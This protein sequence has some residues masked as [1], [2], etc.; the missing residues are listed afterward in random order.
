MR[1]FITLL[2]CLIAPPALAGPEIFFMAGKD[3]RDTY[4]F[5]S[6]PCT[7]A[8]TCGTGTSWSDLTN[9]VTMA[10]L[11]TAGSFAHTTLVHSSGYVTVEY[12]KTCLGSCGNLT[13]TVNGVSISGEQ[14]VWATATVWVTGGVGLEFL[15]AYYYDAGDYLQIRKVIVPKP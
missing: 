9:T 7:G 1:Y 12:Y 3:N 8:W 14:D 11:D 13:P 2:L 5:T 15:F 6:N 4:T 10:R